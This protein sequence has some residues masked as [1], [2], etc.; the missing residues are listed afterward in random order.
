MSTE[1]SADESS[2]AARRHAAVAR[3]AR[4]GLPSDDVEEIVRAAML[5]AADALDTTGWTADEVDL[6]MSIAHPLGPASKPAAVELDWRSAEGVREQLAFLADASGL[7]SASLD[8]DETL[9]SLADLCVPYL[10]D[11]CLID[12]MDDDGKLVERAARA[13]DDE[14]LINVREPRRRRAALGGRGGV[15]SERA[16]AESGQAVVHTLLTDEDFQRASEDEEHLAVFRAFHCH[17]AVVAPL[18]GRTGV[19]GVLSLQLNRAGRSFGPEALA[20]VEQLAARAA[21]ALDNSRLF[22]S[23]N[24]VAR[25][26]QAALL[27]PA[28]PS[29][30]GLGLAAR[31]DVSAAEADVA[32]GGDFYDVIPVSPGSWGMVVGD[33]CGR[34]PD[35]AALTGLVRHTLRTAVLRE[36]VPS[37][38][39]A[40][41]NEAMLQQIDEASFCTAAYV[42]I[43]LDTSGSGRVGISASSAGHPR[44]ILVRADG[45]AEALDC[46]GTLLGVIERPVLT[47]VSID[48]GPGDAVVLYTDGVTEA[49]RGSELFGEARVVATLAPLAGAT[50]EAMADGL[51][52]A[53]ADFRRSAR[54]DTAILVIQALPAS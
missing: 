33:V 20:L 32:I 19:L 23:R 17:S 24:R 8:L 41:T 14:S 1:R 42:R 25:S 18:T 38:V 47:D 16:V 7:L 21:L 34:G 26:L 13:V 45:H 43:D 31:Y 46:T 54:D 48:L 52:A 22:H 49:R 40:Q 3:V 37:K 10:S 6:V 12:L 28:L 44:P 53:V 39:L 27:P 35:A 9:L 50:A 15:Y 11:V 4:V 36:Q 5:F 51:E 2:L 29:I 30:A